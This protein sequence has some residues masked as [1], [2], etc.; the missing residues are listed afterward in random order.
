MASEVK[1]KASGIS[2]TPKSNH[3]K[4]KNKANDQTDKIKST[5][6]PNLFPQLMST[7]ESSNKRSFAS[8]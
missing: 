1:K 5:I 7:L 3:E 6:Q 8:T 2:E 4:R